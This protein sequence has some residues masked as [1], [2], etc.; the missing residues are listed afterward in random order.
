MESVMPNIELGAPY[1]AYID[2]LIAQGLFSTTSEVVK[3]ALRKHMETNDAVK[4]QAYK[5]YVAQAIAEGEAD[6]RAGRVT[7]YTPGY[8]QKRAEEILKKHGK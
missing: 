3:D 1:K 5:E 4:R 7:R 6:I 2:G 8:F